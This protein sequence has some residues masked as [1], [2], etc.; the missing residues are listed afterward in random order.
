MRIGL[1]LD[2]LIDERSEFFAFLSVALRSAGHFAAV[3]TYRDPTSQAKTEAQLGD[4]S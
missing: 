4:C 2:G 1:D 3:L